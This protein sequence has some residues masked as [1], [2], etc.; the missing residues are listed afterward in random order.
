M[1]SPWRTDDPPKD[2]T[3]IVAIGNISEDCGDDACNVEPFTDSIRWDGECW[4]NGVGLSLAPYTDS[5]V[6]ILHW[7]PFPKNNL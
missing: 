5:E 3:L 6:T 4:L 7:L 1:K 2:G